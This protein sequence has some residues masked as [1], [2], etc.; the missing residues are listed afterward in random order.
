MRYFFFFLFYQYSVFGL[1]EYLHISTAMPLK[2]KDDTLVYLVENGNKMELC[3]YNTYGN[4]VIIDKNGKLTSIFSVSR[5]KK[6]HGY[7]FDFIWGDEGEWP[8]IKADFYEEDILVRENCYSEV[9]ALE[10]QIEQDT[11]RSIDNVFDFND[12][13]CESKSW[14]FKVFG[15]VHTLLLIGKLGSQ[16]SLIAFRN[17]QLYLVGIID[18]YEFNKLTSCA[19]IFEKGKIIMKLNFATGF[20]DG[21]QIILL[22][23]SEYSINYEK[24]VLK[25]TDPDF[26]FNLTN[27]RLKQYAHV[28]NGEVRIILKASIVSEFLYPSRSLSLE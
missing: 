24:G 11:R 15:S 27:D 2:F 9:L 21:E 10:K 3:C 20:L 18:R 16:V 7:E 5:F 8:K 19:Y 12:S 6:K 23:K 26:L 1:S 13:I 25:N 22:R 14:Y 4:R 17:G 28:A